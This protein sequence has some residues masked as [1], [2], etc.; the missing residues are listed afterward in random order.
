[1]SDTIVAIRGSCRLLKS[2]YD[3]FRFHWREVSSLLKVGYTREYIYNEIF[4]VSEDETWWK[5]GHDRE[6]FRMFISIMVDDE[7][8]PLDIPV[9]DPSLMPVQYVY[10]ISGKQGYVKIGRS[11]RLEERLRELQRTSP[12]DISLIYKFE[13]QSADKLERLVHED[14]SEHRK[15]GEWFDVSHQDAI[16]SIQRAALRMESANDDKESDPNASYLPA[17]SCIP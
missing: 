12:I 8:V 3:E 15:H 16:A 4:A 11:Y 7:F 14:L 10:V 13:T 5:S 2:R 9:P 17:I 1:M 6:Y